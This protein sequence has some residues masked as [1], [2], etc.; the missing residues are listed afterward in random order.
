MVTSCHWHLSMVCSE[1]ANIA[2]SLG[3]VKT[4]LTIWVVIRAYV[5]AHVGPSSGCKWVSMAMK[6]GRVMACVV[7]H[8]KNNF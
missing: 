2:A 8:D 3:L 1:I 6:Y 5:Y 4:K 7:M